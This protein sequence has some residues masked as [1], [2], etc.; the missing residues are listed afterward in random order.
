[1]KRT[2]VSKWYD[3]ALMPKKTQ[4]FITFIITDSKIRHQQPMSQ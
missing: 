2:E 4:H 1:M 3:C